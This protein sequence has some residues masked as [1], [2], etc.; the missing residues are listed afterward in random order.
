M[1]QAFLTTEHAAAPEEM[2]VLESIR[3]AGDGSE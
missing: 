3:E 1:G 2:T